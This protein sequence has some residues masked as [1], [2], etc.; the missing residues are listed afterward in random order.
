MTL[1]VLRQG[2][3]KEM[4]AEILRA[5]AD[6]DSV[7]GV[8]EC[9]VTGLPVGLGAPF[10]DSVE[11]VLSHLLFSVPAVK[12]VSFGEGFGFASLRGSQANDAWRMQGGQVVT[13]TNHCGGILGGIT[14][15]MPVVFRCCIRA[16]PSIAQ[17]QDT[18]SLKTGENAELAVR[19]RH[20]PCIIPR[21]VPVIEAMAAIGMMEL[22][23]ER[24]SCV[25]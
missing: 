1:P 3:E 18:V 21:A 15:G 17:V 16:T 14:D 13:E 20:D 12:G 23:K 25:R 19:G 5:K 8:I 24:S 7:G 2:L 10:F 9:M 11:S 22:M 6:G 4:E